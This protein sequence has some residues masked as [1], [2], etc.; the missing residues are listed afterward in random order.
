MN[1]ECS[2][3]PLHRQPCVCLRAGPD[4]LRGRMKTA[5]SS[6]RGHERL[7]Y[8]EAHHVQVGWAQDAGVL[9]LKF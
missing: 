8:T 3:R 2:P 5:A 6:F 1:P 4:E 9:D 7:L